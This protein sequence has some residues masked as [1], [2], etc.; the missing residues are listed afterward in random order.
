MENGFNIILW[1]PQTIVYFVMGLV[2]IL[3]IEANFLLFISL[4][5]GLH[6]KFYNPYIYFNY[7]TE[8][9]TG[10]V[11]PSE[12]QTD[13]AP[14]KAEPQEET[15]APPAPAVA[16]DPAPASPIK[17]SKSKLKEKKQVVRVVCI[18]STEK[19][20]LM[21]IE[22]MYQPGFCKSC[23]EIFTINLLIYSLQCSILD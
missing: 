13:E 20:K 5:L 17:R 7:S 19:K 23:R 2:T 12:P 9:Q 8:S 16:P 22:G 6:T 10:S 21:K 18:S 3:N 1:K 14:P 15:V 4:Y 11:P